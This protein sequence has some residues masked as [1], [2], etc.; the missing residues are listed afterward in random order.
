MKRFFGVAM[1]IAMVAC[2]DSSPGGTVGGPDVSGMLR[3]GNGYDVII[4]FSADDGDTNSPTMAGSANLSVRVVNNNIAPVAN[5]ALTRVTVT[6]DGNNVGGSL[7]GSNV[8]TSSGPGTLYQSY[9]VE[10]DAGT[11]GKLSGLSFNP[12]SSLKLHTITAPQGSTIARGM[13]NITWAPSGATSYDLDINRNSSQSATNQTPDNGSRMVNFSTSVSDERVRLKRM[14]SAPIAGA[15]P[16]SRVDLSYR[17]G[18][19][20]L[21]IQ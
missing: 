10:I 3:A 8:W 21:V 9:A 1:S 4:S 6:G 5:A 12:A 17:A 16:A 18:M 20:N 19:R 2:G 7:N 14:L 11:I 13:V 15:S